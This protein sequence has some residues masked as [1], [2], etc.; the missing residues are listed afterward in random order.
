MFRG[1]G[2]EPFFEKAAVEIRIVSDDENDPSQKIVDRSIINPVSRDHLIRDVSNLC[3]LTRDRKT[4]IFEPFPGTEH[5]V[6]P[7]VLTVIFE[8]AN[9]EFDDFVAIGVG[10][11]SFD[12]HHGGD[13]LWNVVGRV[14]FGLSV[15]ST[16]YAIT[17]ALDERSGHLF[18]S[19]FHVGDALDN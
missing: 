5:F 12:I 8:G 14:V 18:E 6:D 19:R 15:Q 11:G 16:G 10:A 17:A 4:G 13:E 7:P 2:W 3:D 1:K 9:P